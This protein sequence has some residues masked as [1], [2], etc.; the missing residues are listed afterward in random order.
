MLIAALLLNV[1]AAGLGLMFRRLGWRSWG[2][3]LLAT[4]CAISLLPFLLLRASRVPAYDRRM[5]VFGLAYALFVYAHLGALLA[6]SF[7]NR[8]AGAQGRGRRVGI[9][10]WVFAVSLLIYAAMSPWLKV[11]CYPTAD[12]PHYLLLT[13][14][15]LFDH[16]FDL[17]NNYARGDYKRFYP[18]EI[19]RTDHHTVR[20]ARGQEVPVHDVG[21]SILLL[22][23]YAVAGRLGAML[24]LNIVG[25]LFALAMFMLAMNLAAQTQAALACWALF[26]FTSPVAVYTSQLY[27]EIVGAALALWAI[28]AYWKFTRAQRWR[29]LILASSAIALLPWFSIRYWLIVAPMLA[30]MGMHLLWGGMLGKRAAWKAVLL[31]LV[32]LAVSLA[33]FAGFDLYWYQTPIPNAGYVLLLRPRASLLTADPLPGV[34][35]LLFDRAFGVLPTAP[36]YLLA[37]AGIFALWQRRRWQ[38]AL[39]LLPAAAYFLLAALNKFWWGGWAPPPRY[40]VTGIAILAPAAAIVLCHRTQR[41]LAGMAAAWSFFIAIAFLAFPLSRYTYWKVTSA[42]LSDFMAHTIKFRWDV[43]FPSFI[44]ASSFD[45]LIAAV[46]AAVAIGLV[47]RL[48]ALSAPP[49]QNPDSSSFSN[50]AR[51]LVRQRT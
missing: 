19:P 39:M 31:T 5:H 29:Y 18:P 16:D 44:R 24:E 11:A 41:V 30:V 36:V 51:E 26:S 45:Y 35:G 43:I 42:A 8:D 20:N 10:V 4:Q 49:A 3:G 46:W 22:P 40:I 13:H 6:Y 14:S 50:G 33:I 32:P 34:P 7:K 25:A 1:F 37:L 48:A 2:T 23:G 28:V 12:E 21:V 47:W 15:L 17:A 27:P 38:A 9:H